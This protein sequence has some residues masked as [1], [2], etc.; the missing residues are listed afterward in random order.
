MILIVSVPVRCHPSLLRAVSEAGVPVGRSAAGH[1]LVSSLRS[2]WSLFKGHVELIPGE[3]HS[4]FISDSVL[5]QLDRAPCGSRTVMV[6]SCLA[7]PSLRRSSI[8]SYIQGGGGES[9]QFATHG[10][11]LRGNNLIHWPALLTTY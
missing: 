10:C 5:Y 6:N 8:C 7:W 9:V 11:S 4:S 3:P 2:M 1:M